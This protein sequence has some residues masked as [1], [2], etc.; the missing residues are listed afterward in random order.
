MT[1]ITR[2]DPKTGNPP[3][4]YFLIYLHQILVI[5]KVFF[6]DHNALLFFKTVFKFTYQDVLFMPYK[7]FWFTSSTMGKLFPFMSLLSLRNKQKLQGARYG[8]K[9][10]CV[11]Y[12][13]SKTVVRRRRYRPTR[14]HNKRT[15]RPVRQKYVLFF[16][17][18]SVN[19]FKIPK[20]KF[21]L[22][23]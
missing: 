21:W 20:Y 2:R 22:T 3:L 11:S 17:I 6:I 23:V 15:S 12:T 4:F 19:H 18:V 5:F 16:W 14:C 8:E 10:Q 7:D 9:E 13:W 1:V